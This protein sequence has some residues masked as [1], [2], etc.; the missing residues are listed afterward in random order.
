MIEAVGSSRMLVTIYQAT[1]HDI[2]ED[3]NIH[4]HLKSHVIH[5]PAYTYAITSS[6]A[7]D[8]TF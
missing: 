1:W 5:V 8:N 2:L 7:I 3:N 6:K 4:S